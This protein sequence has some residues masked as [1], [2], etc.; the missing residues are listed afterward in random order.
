MKTERNELELL[1][2]RTVEY[3]LREKFNLYTGPIMGFL[4]PTA[5]MRYTI[6]NDLGNGSILSE[7]GAWTAS[8]IMYASIF[9]VSIGSTVAGLVAGKL[10]ADDLRNKRLKK[11]SKI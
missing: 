8:A 6:N 4:Y 2:R 7:I 9:P 1:E 11:Q 10:S 3:A 5:A